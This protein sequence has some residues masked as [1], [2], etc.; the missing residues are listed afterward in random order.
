[1]RIT[2]ETT[3]YE[4]EFASKVSIEVPYDDVEINKAFEMFADAL[5]GFGYS[6]AKKYLEGDE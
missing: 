4:P 5:E 2:I 6:G 3:F 1:M